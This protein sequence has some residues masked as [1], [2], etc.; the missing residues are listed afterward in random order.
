MKQ[1]IPLLLIYLRLVIGSI[2]IILSYLQVPY[3]PVVAIV[4]LTVG[5]LSDIFDGII[6][7]QLKISTQKL[8]R[9]D[10]AVDQFFFIAYSIACYLQ[11][12]TFFAL[13]ST[14]LILLFGIEA[15]TYIVSYIKFKKEIAT[16]SMG[17]KI[18]TLLLF[19]TLVEIIVHCQ[20]N[21]LFIICFWVGIITR[22]EII[23]IILLLKTWTNDVPSLYHAWLLRIGKPIKRSKLF[24][25]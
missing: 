23:G 15:G 20:S 9:L 17:A 6:A 25:G 10:S 18:F 2:I 3:Y 12:P 11:C 13:H 5:L 7:R 14:K 1:K 8:R 4:L 19:A 22:L 24:N 21:Y 16:H